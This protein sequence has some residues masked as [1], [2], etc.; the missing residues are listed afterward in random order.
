MDS[1]ELLL[2]HGAS[3]FPLIRAAHD[4]AQSF[5]IEME[6]GNPDQLV[7]GMKEV[8]RTGSSSYQNPFGEDDTEC[9]LDTF[10]TLPKPAQEKL[11]A[12]TKQGNSV[13]E[14]ALLGWIF[15]GEASGADE[16]TPKKKERIETLA[17][18]PG[19]AASSQKKKPKLELVD[20][21][22]KAMAMFGETKQIKTELMACGGRY[23][24][25]LR[26][27]GGGTAPGWIFSK[28]RRAVLDELMQA[29]ASSEEDASSEEE[30]V[31]ARTEVKKEEDA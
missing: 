19:A 21:S 25:K 27:E 11:Y 13:S 22:E 17:T 26:R 2:K 24:P 10:A 16:V 29:Y 12:R 7:A 3:S 31:V 30:E 15:P 8:L 9:F 28:R 5:N 23:N 20:Y 14:S 18:P 4:L 1:V 6:Y